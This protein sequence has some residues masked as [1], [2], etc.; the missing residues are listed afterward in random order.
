MPRN[1]AGL[2]RDCMAYAALGAVEVWAEMLTDPK[3]PS[4]PERIAARIIERARD[5]KVQQQAE[6]LAE[7]PVSDEPISAEQEH[8][9][10]M[11]EYADRA[12]MIL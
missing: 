8:L 10:K 12:A 5:F 9:E 1:E 11:A 7:I 2:R 6:A 4:P 3:Y